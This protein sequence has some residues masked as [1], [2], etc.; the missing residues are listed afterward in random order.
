MNSFTK[1]INPHLGK[2]LEDIKMDKEYIRGNGS[3]LY[4]TKGDRYLD[5]IA[6][7]GAIPFGYNPKEIWDCIKEYQE[8][9]I[10]SFIQPSALYIASKLAERLI[11]VTPEGLDYVT[12]TNSGA[13]SVEAAIKLARSRTGRRGILATTNSFHGKTLAA[14]SATGN[15][16]YQKPFGAPL[17]GFAS[18]K[19]GDLQALESEL[20]NNPEAYAAFIVEPIQGEGGI[21]ESPQGYLKAAKEICRKYGVIF[22]LDEIQ[23]GLGRTGNLFAFEE[24]DVVP[25]LLLLAKALGG[26]IIPIGACIASEDVYNEDFGNKHSSTFA[27]NSLACMV[28]L[29]ALE[30]LTRDNQKL[31]KEVRVKGEMFKNQLLK[32]QEK[33]PNIIKMIRGKGL[34]LGIEFG[35]D[36][37]T[38][39][40]SMIGI[41]AEQELLTPVI[42]S[43]LLNNEKIRVAP[44]L[45]GNQVI[46]IEPSL[47]INTEQI[48]DCI[49]GLDK[50]LQVLS[51]GNTA[52]FLSYLIDD[53]RDREFLKTELKAANKIIPSGDEEGKFAFLIHPLDLKNYC[54]FDESLYVFN[55]DELAELTDRW[56]D[57]V[58]PFVTAKVR[59]RAAS[60][61]TA[62]GEFIAV[63]RT[64]EQ[65]INMPKETVLGELKAA[66]ELARERG[67]K[68]VGLGAYTSVVSMGGLYLR[69]EGVPL[70]T[71]NSYTVVAG[72]EAVLDALQRLE[73]APAEAVVAVVGATGSIGKGTS[74]LIS[75]STAR[76][77]LL[78]N[79]KN[80]ESSIKRLYKIAGEV[81]KYL[82]TLI[83]K[84]HRFNPG[85]I[86]DKLLRN[87]QGVLPHWD[88]PVSEFID[89][90][91]S[92]DNENSPIVVTT[93][94]EH[95]LPAA[96]VVI[97]ATNT[98]EKIITAD[99]I[100]FGAVVCDLSRPGN[101]SKEVEEKRPDVLVIDG[102]VIEVPGRPS[103]GWNF[104]F[105]EGLAYACMAETMMLA[106]EHHYTHTSLG[107]SGISLENIL[108][109][110]ELADKHGF[111]V[112]ELR[113]F[114]R[115]LDQL[116]WQNIID[117]R[118]SK[119]G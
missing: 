107:S 59:I 82:T 58:E 104:G 57:M 111:K 115:P 103:L 68:L 79:P 65:L 26:G 96:D 78:G 18:I 110:K 83:D 109:T 4:D 72:V 105:E 106:L 89:F 23:T 92:L 108:F 20:Q 42:S 94:T 70:T 55:Q 44:T 80:H 63:P 54:E 17:A 47:T 87:Y 60:G 37:D 41:M 77:I 36:Q 40:G 86:G 53:N 90:A 98:I 51:S 84:N 114:D 38:F 116:K 91:M 64:T 46:R 95:Y 85:T 15:S 81:Y 34:M 99:N 88:A 48:N 6:A 56:S 10:P 33:Y 14:L 50:M 22:V 5:C 39:P 119:V 1:Y 21:V 112:A 66:I 8:S 102:G 31:I 29:K 61:K 117:A 13:E 118:S 27:G 101:V 35:V 75:E 32:L 43:Y 11:E 73:V 76:M 67:A 30:L 7:Y 3:Y 52:K 69:K 93:E 19:Y 45:N 97:S 71:G 9:E 16:S 100:K 24:E 25:D 113:S 28:G 49:Q 74:V 12:F 62:Y 2:L